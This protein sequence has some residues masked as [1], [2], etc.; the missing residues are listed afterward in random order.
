[1]D[2]KKAKKFLIKTLHRVKGAN[3]QHH[4][5][6]CLLADIKLNIL[7]VDS[8]KMTKNNID[9][10]FR[11]YDKSKD[12]DP[13]DIYYLY[14]GLAIWQCCTCSN[15]KL[16]VPTLDDA[17]DLFLKADFYILQVFFI[18]TTKMKNIYKYNPK[19]LGF[20]HV[21]ILNS[22]FFSYICF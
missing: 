1:M 13:P 5:V 8:V 15:R 10:I 11:Q 2:M 21:S 7:L 17:I 22:S 20:E 14:K 4:I 19:V 6:H 18:F 9:R 12:F 3:V 16:N